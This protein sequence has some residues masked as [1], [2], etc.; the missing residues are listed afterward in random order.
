MVQ[1]LGGTL[2]REIFQAVQIVEIYVG[3][4]I[5]AELLLSRAGLPEGI[6]R[7]KYLQILTAPLALFIQKKDSIRN[8]SGRQCQQRS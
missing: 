1:I 2:L 4:Y 7:G 3:V 8:V 5:C 6:E